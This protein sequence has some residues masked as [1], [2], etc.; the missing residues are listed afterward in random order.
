VGHTHWPRD[1]R[2]GPAR[3]SVGRSPC[4]IPELSEREPD[5]AAE[6]SRTFIEF[7][8]RRT[9]AGLEVFVLSPEEAPDEALALEIFGV[10]EEALRP[11]HDEIM[12][13]TDRASYATFTRADDLTTEAIDLEWASDDEAEPAPPD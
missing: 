5:L 2:A 7:R 1:T 4:S 10:V 8:F 13:R 3:G 6:A 11:L 9:D 12:A